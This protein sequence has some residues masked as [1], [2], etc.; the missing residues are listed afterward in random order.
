MPEIVRVLV[1]DGALVVF[2][3]AGL[4]ATTVAILRDARTQRAEPSRQAVRF[5]N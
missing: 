5:D 4:L 1:S 2:S 3:A